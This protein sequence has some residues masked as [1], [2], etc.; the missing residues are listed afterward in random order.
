M[1]ITSVRRA[2]RFSN[3]GSGNAVLRGSA[4]RGLLSNEFINVFYAEY[5][6]PDQFFIA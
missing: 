4:S 1:E 2:R 5:N 6:G 3:S